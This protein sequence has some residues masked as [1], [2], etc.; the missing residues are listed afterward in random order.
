MISFSLV[1]K[2]ATTYAVVTFHVRKFKIA[3]A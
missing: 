2:R 1:H 3:T